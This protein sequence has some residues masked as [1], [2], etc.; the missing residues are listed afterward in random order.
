MHTFKIIQV[1]Q[2]EKFY[3]DGEIQNMLLDYSYYQYIKFQFKYVLYPSIK[4]LKIYIDSMN[5]I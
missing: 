5:I 4:G 2:V 1:E 3:R